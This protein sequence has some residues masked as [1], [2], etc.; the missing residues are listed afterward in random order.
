MPV[1]LNAHLSS[2][3][4]LA[5]FAIV[6][7]AWGANWPVVQLIVVDVPPVWTTAIRCWIAL[8]VLIL[9][10]WNLGKLARPKAQDFSVIGSYSLLHMCAFSTLAAAGQQFIP[11]STA[12]VLAYTTPIWVGILAPL[13]LGEKMTLWKVLGIGI[14]MCGLVLIFSPTT[15]DWQDRKVVMGCGLTLLASI[16]WSAS[17]VHVRSREW[18]SSPLQLIVW[19]TALAAIIMSTIALL[20]EG[21]PDITWSGRLVLLLAY[22]GIIASALAYWAM[23]IV[24]QSHPAHTTSLG[25]LVT[26]LI[27]MGLASLTLGEPISAKLFL[28]AVLIVGGIATAIVADKACCS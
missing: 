9:L 14:S 24:N 18:L 27:G 6:T 22:G 17:I 20:S 11:A 21:W 7:F 3:R 15:F 1:V 2:A 25:V 23:L 16:C 5:L 19:Q 13:F 8:T 26:P 28:S 12:V 4:S 10:A